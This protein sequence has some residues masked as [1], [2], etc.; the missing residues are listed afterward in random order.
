MSY[1]LNRYFQTRG[2]LARWA[3]AFQM[4]DRLRAIGVDEVGCSIDF[5]VDFDS[6]ISGLHHLDTLRSSVIQAVG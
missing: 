1:A 4:I 2:L 5:G 3:L 6:V